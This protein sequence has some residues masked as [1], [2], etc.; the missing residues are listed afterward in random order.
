MSALLEIRDLE[1]SYGP[2]A[3]LKGV[4]LSVPQGGI[5]CLIGANGAGKSTVLKTVSGLLP[6]RAGAIAFE[7][8]NLRQS[9]AHRIVG[10][11]LTHCPEGRGVFPELRV[12]ENLALGAY[13]RPDKA[14]MER[15]LTYAYEL[16]PRLFE[17]RSQ[18]AGTL[19]GGEQQMLAIGRSL[20][21]RPK[22]LMLDEPS[23][24]L[25]PQ[26]VEMIFGVIQK[27]NAEGCSVLLVEQNAHQA[28][29]ISHHAYVLETGKIALEGPAQE[30]AKNP[31]VIEAYLG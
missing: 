18:V 11:G 26:I 3:A 7:G 21:S 8:V 25:A 19:S 15:G 31:K 2:V 22:L 23:L 17:R 12:D 4:S 6:A 9:A 13:T 10:L 28:L 29:A 30:V 1:V 5:V 16:F 20:M 24:G 27:V 14:E